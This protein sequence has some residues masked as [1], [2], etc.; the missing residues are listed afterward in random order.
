M[1]FFIFLICSDYF[2]FYSITDKYLTVDYVKKAH[3]AL[4]PIYKTKGSI[5]ADLFSVSSNT[6]QPFT[7]TIVYCGLS[8]K[9]P[10]GHVGIIFGRSSMMLKSILTHVGVID[11]DYIMPIG[12][13]LVNFS[14]EECLIQK[15]QRIAQICFL[16]FTRAQINEV[17]NIS[18]EV[19]RK[20]GF[21]S[22]GV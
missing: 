10:D 3:F 18:V 5:G 2:L 12:V 17:Q 14:K 4:P 15:N 20:G 9:I 16:K 1:T 6:L 22:T 8:M 11:N 7:P 13:I 21:G 19:E